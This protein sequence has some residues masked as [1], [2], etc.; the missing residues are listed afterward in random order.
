MTKMKM[1][2]KK[3]CP[4]CGSENVDMVAGGVTGSW[5]CIDCGFAGAFPERPHEDDDEE[6]PLIKEDLEEIKT[7]ME[8]S[9]KTKRSKK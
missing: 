6:N 8:K 4:Q 3:F 1:L 2:G 5:V 7:S 9:N